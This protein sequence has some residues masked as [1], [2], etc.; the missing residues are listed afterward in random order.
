MKLLL[1]LI[2][3]FFLNNCSFDNKSGVW[4]NE[5]SP[6]IDERIIFK[7]FKKI[8]TTESSY[9]QII[10]LKEDFALNLSEAITNNSWNDI[11]YSSNNN[12]INFKY[13]SLNKIIF[14]SKKLTN[15]LVN[16]NKLY[17]DGNLI[18]T[19]D[20]GNIIIFSK[21]KNRIVKKFNFYKKKFKKVGKKLNII[22]HNEVIYVADNLGY[23]YAYNYKIDKI[24]WAK[25]YKIPFSSNL[26][27]FQNKITVANQDNN[28][29]ILNKNNG[30]L[31]KSIPTEQTF[32]KNQFTNNLSA[33]NAER[34]F[35]LNSF[36][37]LYSIDL[38]TMSITWFNN[39]NKSFDLSPSNLFIG[40]E[41]VNTNREILISSNRNTYLIN[42]KNGSILKK[43]NFSSSVKPLII[44]NIVFFLTNN[45]FFIALNLETKKILFSY[46]ITKIEKINLKKKEYGNYTQ[47][48]ILNGDIYIF[49]KNSKVLIFEI[50]GRFKEIIKLAA[51]N[52]TSPISIDNS[53]LFL[54]N[55]NKLIFL[56]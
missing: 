21:D 17:Q 39:F 28:L 27:I 22:L 53:I 3:F 41:I 16:I 34:L 9:N 26:K 32:I 47:M 6:A 18:I 38:E 25:N 12:F 43:F 50:N 31:L 44:D 52:Y 42:L 11:F 10:P 55:K 29:Y 4:E 20:K 49:L 14:K 54:N 48:M 24:L 19:D 30:N 40:K 56:N 37:S 45:N 15:N 1:L 36:G 2:I 7:E 33:Y 23:T 35:Y 5:N 46:D 8:T 51:K 13:H